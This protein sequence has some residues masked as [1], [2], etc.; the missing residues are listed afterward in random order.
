MFPIDNLTNTEGTF[1]ISVIQDDV[2]KP[3]ELGSDTFP[4]LLFF[5]ASQGLKDSFH[6]YQNGKSV[7]RL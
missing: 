3:E 6:L 1:K 4:Y 5:N 2:K 7:I